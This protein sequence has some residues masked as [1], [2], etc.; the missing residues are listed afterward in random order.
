MIYPDY[1]KYITRLF[2]RMNRLLLTF[3]GGE[4]F[5]SSFAGALIGFAAYI[6]FTSLPNIAPMLHDFEERHA[7]SI[8]SISIPLLA[9]LAGIIVFFLR[10]TVRAALSYLEGSSRSD[11]NYA[12]EAQWRMIRET[13]RQFEKILNSSAPVLTDETIDRLRKDTEAT[14]LAQFTPEVVTKAL[15]R[16]LEERYSKQSIDS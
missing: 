14:L 9:V 7:D 1:P 6:A 3:F 12:T 5:L 15:A 11:D 2:I 8:K 16:H 4:V 13:Q 10:S